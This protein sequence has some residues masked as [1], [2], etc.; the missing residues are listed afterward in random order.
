MVGVTKRLR[1][2][3]FGLLALV[4]AQLPAWADE[5]VPRVLML[6]AYNYTFPA[7]TIVSEVARKRL[8]ERIPQIEIEAEFLDLPQRSD[9]ALETHTAD[10]LKEKYA[11]I[12]FDAVIAIG[13]GAVS[14][15]VARRDAFAPGAPVIFAGGTRADLPRLQLPDDMR[16]VIT[17]FNP[18]K[19]LELAQR[20]QRNVR[21]VVVIG[22]SS[23]LDR[24]WQRTVREAFEA[25]GS[26][27]EMNYLFDWNYDAMIEQVSRLPR[28]TI[29]ILLTAYADAAGRPL[30]PRD[31]AAAVAKASSV[32]VYGPFDTFIGTGIVGG[33][34]E[35]YVS[36]GQAVGEMTLQ[37][38]AG[39]VDA[40]KPA[41]R[42]NTGL[43]YRVD[44]RAMRRWNLSENKLPP[45]T[46]VL[47]KPYSMWQQH[48]VFISLVVLVVGLQSL[49]MS[50][51]L[52][53]R[54]RR[55][56][57][58]KSLRDSEA[59]MTFT[60]SS[61]NVGMWQFNR[62]T[63]EVWST[64]HCRTMLG[65]PRDTELTR[66]SFLA[67][68]HPDDRD[69]VIAAMRSAEAPQSFDARIVLPTAEVRWYRIRSVP[70]PDAE[71]A[72]GKLAGIIVDIT[73]QKVAEADAALQRQQVM[74]LMRV[75][76]LGELSGAIA[77]EVN[78]PLTAIMSNAQAA[79]H[80]LKQSSPDLPEVR[81]ALKDIVTE[82]SRAGEVIQRLRMLMKKGESHFQSV[83][84][85]E[86]VRSTANL[87]HS[88]LIARDVRLHTSL[89][90]GLPEVFG[91]L[92][93]LQ[94]VLI[95]LIVNASDAMASTLPFRRVVS[96]STNMLP[97]GAVEM[98]IKD[99]GTG[100]RPAD[101]G[102]LFEPFYTT[103]PH[104]L[105]LGLS[106][107][108]TILQAHHGE[109][110]LADDE[111]GGAVAILTLPARQVLL[112]DEALFAA[113]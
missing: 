44:A 83:D 21:R 93:Q 55:R 56:E 57:A 62:E 7:A 76:M 79:L 23:K 61:A 66:E 60:A 46:V 111:L 82:D 49:L 94:Q 41:I 4:L 33:Y 10:Y 24:H 96:I 95:N 110:T 107:C 30:V 31:V 11:G 71:G 54:R 28:D 88:E 35:T 67:A 100:L 26:R 3:P 91:D 90:T 109:L 106:I 16:G 74:H 12:K 80:L 64:E 87:L 1:G 42:V 92:V 17:G 37:V 18:E 9:Q 51:L 59:R 53:Q 101:R 50:A 34:M 19:T 81:E 108:A 69:T 68:V 97:S 38:L 103:K 86:L 63:G 36:L 47:F 6:H 40:A 13:I 58:E 15:A 73:G 113:K 105:G 45:D 39:T 2:L 20:L 22:G 70:T 29:V 89:A 99:N 85:H 104:G 78:Q 77:H 32:P 102:K 98:R 25:S 8:M 84:I 43:T 65:L 27:L 75:S 48:R 14:F 112:T 5:A 52:F 72:P